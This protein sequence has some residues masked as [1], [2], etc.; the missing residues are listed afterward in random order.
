MDKE[1]R[2]KLKADYKQAIR[3]M[4]VYQ[5]RNIVNGKV[6]IGSSLNLEK[7]TNSLKFQLELN[8]YINKELQLEWNEYGADKFEFEILD[9]FKPSENDPPGKNYLK[10]VKELE[11]LWLDKLQP[12]DEKGYNKI[13]IKK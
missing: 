13:K 8:G 4:G 12:Y 1:R 3:P 11:E 7:V 9:E 2:A 6:M 10:E 5:L